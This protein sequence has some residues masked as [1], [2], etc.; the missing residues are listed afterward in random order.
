MRSFLVCLTFISSAGMWGVCTPGQAEPKVNS[1]LADLAERSAKYHQPVTKERFSPVLHEMQNLAR[2]LERAVGGN[3]QFA[4]NWKAYLKWNLLEPHLAAEPKLDL[5]NLNDLDKV[6]R[7]FRANRAGLELPVFTRAAKAIDHYREAAVWHALASR[8]DTVPLYESYA[9][10]LGEQLRRH[11]EAA[12]VETTRQIGKA[13]GTI[14]ALGYSPELVSAIRAAYYKPNVSADVSSRALNQL[15]APV[16]Q[17]RGVRDCILGATIRGTA[18]TNGLV[19]FQPMDSP[20][21]IDLTIH[22]NGVIHSQ[23][24]AFRKPVQIRSSGVTNY[25]ATK[26]ILLDDNYFSSTNPAVNARTHTRTQSIQKTGGR[27]GR[28]L[29]EKIAWKKVRQSKGQSEAIA[30]RHAE[31]QIASGFQEQVLEGLTNGRASYIEKLRVPLQRVDLL[32]KSFHLSSSNQAVHTQATLVSHDQITTASLPPG[33]LTSNDLTVQVHE[34]AVNNFLPTFLAGATLQQ[35]RADVPPKLEG[36]VPPWLKKLAAKTP[37]ELAE[38]KSATIAAEGPTLA[39]GKEEAKFRPWRFL[40][41]SEHPASVHFEDQKLILRMRLAELEASGEEDKEPIKNWDFVVTYKV[42]QAGNE[43][44][45]RRE[46]DVEAFPTGF[47]PR[48]NERLTGK[49]VAIRNN[50]A[51][52]LNKRADSGEGFPSEIPIPAVK[53]PKAGGQE[54]TLQLAQ[55]ECDKGWLTLGYR[56]P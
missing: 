56:V 8:R 14:E 54:L 26:R 29:V 1:D 13:L 47:D 40:L 31:R 12:T 24:S 46:G 17:I 39:M 18:I 52:N 49:Q 42:L 38:G 22:L 48:W 53:L 35:D 6:L 45:L 15:A 4:Q 16:C 21:H 43:V 32:G 20:D 23:T 51:K 25:I 44:L 19:S 55:L 41:N 28:R 27:F 2:A 30:A 36:D 11:Q 9:K 34:S 10:G 37:N 33:K 5:Q 3:S 7:R 50:L